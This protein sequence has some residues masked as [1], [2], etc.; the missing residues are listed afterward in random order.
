VGV[1]G[2]WYEEPT[3][4]KL[5]IVDALAN[6][7]NDLKNQ[8]FTVAY[9]TA[10]WLTCRVTPLKKQVHPGWEYSKIHDPTRETFDTPRPRKFRNF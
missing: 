10:H 1:T 9:V 3:L 8:G 7:V 6:R 2:T 4:A 5:P